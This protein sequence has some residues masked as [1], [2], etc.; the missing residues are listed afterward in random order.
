MQKKDGA[1]KSDRKLSCYFN[2]IVVWCNDEKE[3][4]YLKMYIRNSE[5]LVKKIDAKI[6]EL[7]EEE[8][9]NKAG[10]KQVRSLR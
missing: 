10:N 4:N 6:A 3:K 7:E 1:Y 9:R 5:D 2:N 8:R